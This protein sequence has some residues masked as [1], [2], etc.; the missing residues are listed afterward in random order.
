MEKKELKRYEVLIDNYKKARM[1]IAM[2]EKQGNKEDRK[3]EIW[4]ANNLR[5]LIEC[6]L[7]D[8]TEDKIKSLMDKLVIEFF[9]TYK[10]K[11]AFKNYIK[12]LIYQYET[13][14]EIVKAYEEN[15]SDLMDDYGLLEDLDDSSDIRRWARY[16]LVMRIDENENLLGSDYWYPICKDLERFVLIKNKDNQTRNQADVEHYLLPNKK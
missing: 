12:E 14:E 7:G 2:F 3:K 16:Q 9:D 10:D 5:Y 1:N 15:D 13:W 4:K 8:I 6:L 11:Y